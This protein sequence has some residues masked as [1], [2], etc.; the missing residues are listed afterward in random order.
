MGVDRRMWKMNPEQLQEHLK[1]KNRARQFK[2]KKKHNSKRACR[3][4]SQRALPLSV[5]PFYRREDRNSWVR[6]CFGLSRTSA[7]VPD[8]TTTPSAMKTT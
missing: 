3:D 1:L 5:S 6:A 2:D 8:S 7:G 4:F